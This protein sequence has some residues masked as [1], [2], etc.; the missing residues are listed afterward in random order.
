MENETAIYCWRRLRE[1]EIKDSVLDVV[2]LIP[3]RH[4][5]E[6]LSMHLD[7]RVWNAGEKFR[8]KTKILKSCVYNT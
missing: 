3:I 5:T 4:S 1:M 2:C 7:T 6:M 8:L